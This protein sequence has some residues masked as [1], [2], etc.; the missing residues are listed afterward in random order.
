MDNHVCHL[1]L[2]C[3]S[4]FIC[5]PS[6]LLSPKGIPVN[7]GY[8][9]CWF[10]V[11]HLTS[12]AVGWGG[13]TGIKT[14]CWASTARQRTQN[15]SE[16]RFRPDW[17]FNN[18][19]LSSIVIGLFPLKYEWVVSQLFDNIIVGKFWCVKERIVRKRKEFFSCSFL[20]CL[21]MLCFNPPC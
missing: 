14:C 8:H 15:P 16:V 21:W 11:P 9:G 2:S 10:G 17:P 18:P 1:K 5:L 3:L 7:R 6:D 4:N 19:A 20:I 13:E 12:P